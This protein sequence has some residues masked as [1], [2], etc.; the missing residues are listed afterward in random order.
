MGKNDKFHGVN[1]ELENVANKIDDETLDNVSGG[2]SANV[3]G[4][5]ICTYCGKDDSFVWRNGYRFC[6]RCSKNFV[7]R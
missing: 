5:V 2:A 3:P 7:G 1:P 4:I 6:T